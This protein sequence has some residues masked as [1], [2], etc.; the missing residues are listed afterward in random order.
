MHIALNYFVIK[1]EPEK[2]KK[3]NIDLMIGTF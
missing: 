1:R 3:Y 2:N